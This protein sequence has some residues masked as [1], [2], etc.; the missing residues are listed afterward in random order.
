[1]KFES[2]ILGARLTT[3]LVGKPMCEKTLLELYAERTR[4][5]EAKGAALLNFNCPYPAC[6]QELKAERVGPGEFYTPLSTCPHCEQFYWKLVQHTRAC[7][8]LAFRKAISDSPASTATEQLGIQIPV[9][10]APTY[11]EGWSYADKYI[12]GIGGDLAAQSTGKWTEEK[13]NG[14]WDRIA[15]QREGQSAR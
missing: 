10:S 11:A 7:G 1:V 5:L 13:A 9:N 4:L 8:L 14:F 6:S 15:A 2:T 12:R 3:F